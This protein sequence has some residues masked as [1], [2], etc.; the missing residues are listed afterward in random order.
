MSDTTVEALI[1][2]F[3]AWLA[4]GERSYEEAMEAW[5]TSCP[6]LPVWEDA[7]ERGLVMTEQANGITVVRPTEAG[8][9]L[10]RRKNGLAMPDYG[11]V[12]SK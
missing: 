9:Q 4:R 1:V 10:L 7:N 12:N 11:G 8:L 6:K 5:R 2:D 3:L